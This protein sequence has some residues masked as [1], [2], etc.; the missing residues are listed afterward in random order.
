MKTNPVKPSRIFQFGCTLALE[1][2]VFA[3][4]SRPLHCAVLNPPSQEGLMLGP[5]ILHSLLF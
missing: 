5:L 1:A 3:K 2:P 4:A